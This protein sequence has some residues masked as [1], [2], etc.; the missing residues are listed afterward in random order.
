[1]DTGEH[2]E[3]VPCVLADEVTYMKSCHQMQLQ[4]ST[5]K[6]SE[7]LNK[8]TTRKQTHRSTKMVVEPYNGGNPKTV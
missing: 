6:T 4:N 1:M 2:V 8:I 7:H 3:K 5:K